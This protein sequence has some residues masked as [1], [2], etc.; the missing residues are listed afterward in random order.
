MNDAND[1]LDTEPIEI[2]N[3]PE[4]I[5]LQVDADGD[6]PKDFNDLHGVSWCTDETPKEVRDKVRQYGNDLVAYSTHRQFFLDV[7]EYVERLK[8]PPISRK[9]KASDDKILKR[10]KTELEKFTEYE[11]QTLPFK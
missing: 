2:N 11:Q 7:R 3:I 10:I 8:Y 5:Y 1:L 9:E 6:T 4:K